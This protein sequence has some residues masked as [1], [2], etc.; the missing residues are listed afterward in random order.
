M[1]LCF[2]CFQLVF[3]QYCGIQM[4]E[5]DIEKLFGGSEEDII[6][7]V[8]GE[9][10]ASEAVELFYNNYSDLHDSLVI[11]DRLFNEIKELLLF[12]EKNSKSLSIFTGKGKRSLEISLRKLGLDN[13]F[14]YLVSDDDVENSK[15]HK[16][17]LLKILNHFGV[18]ASE[19]IF[20]GD[21][22][23]DI[24]SANQA[25]IDSIGVNWFRHRNFR[26]KPKFISNQPRDI[27]TKFWIKEE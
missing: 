7:K 6:R 2:K 12:L 17:G 8:V 20:F 21:S 19:A 13:T 22:D 11:Q 10:K 26:I 25:Y 9:D 5:S 15:P 14:Q 1:P 3:E 18:E 23:L 4:D 16:E 27:M 24:L